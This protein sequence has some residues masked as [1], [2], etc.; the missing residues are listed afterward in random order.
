[1]SHPEEDPEPPVQDPVKKF[2]TL[3]NLESAKRSLVA[4]DYEKFEQDLK[5]APYQFFR[6]SYNAP[7]DFNGS[8][9]FIVTNFVTGLISELQEKYS[10]YFFIVHRCIQP[11]SNS[12][13]YVF[14]S[15]WIVNTPSIR[16]IY[17]DRC[18]DF[19]FT[20]VDSSN[21]EEFT[22]FLLD[23]RHLPVP[24]VEEEPESEVVYDDTPYDPFSFGGYDDEEE[25]QVVDSKTTDCDIPPETTTDEV[26]VEASDVPS[27]TT[28][29]E[30]KIESSDVPIEVKVEEPVV[31]VK[32]NV[33]I[34]EQYLH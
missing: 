14:E 11:S 25:E 33:L 5:L 7:E 6:S 19:T 2:P 21:T 23:F 16:D 13:N 30:V 22:Q 31:E 17:G 26:K 18:D 3:G 4:R 32:F 20:S 34:S 12:K 29:D 27:E 15:L 9:P 28:T 8:A 10:K 1:M 24:E